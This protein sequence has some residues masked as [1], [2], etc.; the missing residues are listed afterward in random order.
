MVVGR[1]LDCTVNNIVYKNLFEYLW[2]NVRHDRSLLKYRVI[3][4]VDDEIWES[5]NPAIRS[6]WNLGIK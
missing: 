6:V 2:E 1:R 3:I 5:V 4:K